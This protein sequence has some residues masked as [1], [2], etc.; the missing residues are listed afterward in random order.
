M[1]AG[2]PMWG[3][4]SEPRNPFGGMRSPLIGRSSAYRGAPH[5]LDPLRR[6]RKPLIGSELRTG[7]SEGRCLLSNPALSFVGWDE[8]PDW[9]ASPIHSRETPHFLLGEVLRAV[10]D[11]LFAG[12]YRTYWGA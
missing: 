9:L 11:W 5:S 12:D 6:E 1:N 10:S 8:P 4:S 3:G 7:V 2:G